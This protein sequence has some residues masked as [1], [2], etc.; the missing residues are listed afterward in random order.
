MILQIP[1]SIYFRGT[2]GFGL[3]AIKMKRRHAVKIQ[4]Y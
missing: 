2:I 3:H 1:Y 4:S